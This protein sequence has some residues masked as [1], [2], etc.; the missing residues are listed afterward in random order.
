MPID[1]N[2]TLALAESQ[3]PWL[4]EQLDND[5]VRNLYHPSPSDLGLWQ[6]R[7]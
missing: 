4:E 2:P 7:N 5:N 1:E 6:D 3:A